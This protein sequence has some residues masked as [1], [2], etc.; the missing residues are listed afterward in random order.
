[1]AFG[2]ATFRELQ[3][4]FTLRPKAFGRRVVRSAGQIRI[5]RTFRALGLKH[6]GYQ[7]SE[8][9]KEITYWRG[10]V[11]ATLVVAPGRPQGPPL[12]RDFFT[13]SLQWREASQVR[14]SFSCS[15]LRSHPNLGTRVERVSVDGWQERMFVLGMEGVCRDQEATKSVILHRGVIYSSHCCNMEIRLCGVVQQQRFW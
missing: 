7:P 14:G 15:A 5:L 8:G 4:C 2:P 9:V 10:V 1:V 13:A 11:G 3:R 6:V 12:Q